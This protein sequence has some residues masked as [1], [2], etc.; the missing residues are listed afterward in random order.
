M[1]FTL[2][3][4]AALTTSTAYAGGLGEMTDAE[5]SAFREE[6]KAYLMEHPEV[7]VEAMTELQAREEL[8]SADRDV[9]MLAANQDAIFN[10]P[11][12]WV[13]GNPDGDITVVE[14]MDYR[15]G[16]CRKAYQEV[17]DLVSADGNIRFV[18]KEFPILGEESLYSAQFALAVRALYGDDAYKAAHD[19]LVTLRGPSTP[20][21]LGRL[22]TDLGH[23]PAAV[24]E[25]MSS[26]EVEAVIMSN[27]AL[28]NALEINGTPT[29]VINGTML[30]GYVPLDGMRQ[31]VA[32]ER[33]EG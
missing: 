25:K 3:L 13:G 2:A 8:A 33:E 30:R 4:L 19:A 27:H 21:T 18:L 7:I 32:G 1:R 15:C 14:F 29:F 10:S 22:A 11:G 5:R 17:E 26:P 28:A 9:Q 20:E 31:I 6:V 23:D 12:D 24:T 16:Y